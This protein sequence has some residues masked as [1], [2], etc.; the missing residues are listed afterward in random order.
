MSFYLNGQLYDSS[1]VSS[2]YD[3]S[4]ALKSGSEF[5]VG[6][7]PVG[8]LQNAL[9]M[10][11]QQS[12]KASARSLEYAQQNQQWAAEQA[13]IANNF[14]AAEAAK[15]RDWQEYMSNTAHQR[16]IAD[17]KAAGLNPV[18]SA[19]GGNG[20]SV[21]SGASASANLPSGAAGQSDTSANS[22]LVSI[23]GSMLAAQTQLT[24]QA[25]SART[26]EAV[27]DKY[28]AMSRITAEIAAAA[29]MSNARTSAAA[30]MAN[31]NTA[32]AASRYGADMQYQI[33]QD[34]PNTMIRVLDSILS[35]N[36]SSI[37]SAGG[38]L[39]NEVYDFLKKLS[40]NKSGFD[41]FGNRSGNFN[42]KVVR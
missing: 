17:L 1:N 20:A 25:V 34:F 9:D 31:A 21:T 12:E 15:N 2:L 11:T 28:T 16:E 8:S 14:N 19:M 36:G 35:D 26:Q 27:A 32:A 13:Q 40:G 5:G 18:L 30:S 42:G 7:T 39:L 6:S 22:A 41:L 29:S 24:N 23:L 38:K 10:I 37:G 4:G 33:Q 3:Q